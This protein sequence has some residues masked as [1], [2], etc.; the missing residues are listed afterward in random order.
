MN[1]EVKSFLGNL[2]KY[3]GFSFLGDGSIYHNDYLLLK[4]NTD[5]S[6]F[7]SSYLTL[8]ELYQNYVELFESC[9]G[10][11]SL[12]N[13]QLVSYLR[14]KGKEFLYSDMHYASLFVTGDGFLIKCKVYPHDLAYLSACL[15]VCSETYWS[16]IQDMIRD[17]T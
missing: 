8:G 16:H 7:V 3:K 9:I 11:S 5:G 4:F 1:Q 17:A 12:G 2:G 6:I 15:G 10:S 14:K 13:F